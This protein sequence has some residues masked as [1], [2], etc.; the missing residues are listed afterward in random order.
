MEMNITAM[1]ESEISDSLM[2]R[3]MGSIYHSD[4]YHVRA[5]ISPRGTQ[6]SF[7]KYDARISLLSSDEKWE[8]ALNGRNLSD[9]MTI[10]HAYEI[11]GSAFQNLSIGRTVT[12]EG[13][14]RF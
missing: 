13:I 10:Q 4:E 12:L 3:A 9:E 7:T 6:G 8:I 1:W 2:I 11:A 5:D 14:V